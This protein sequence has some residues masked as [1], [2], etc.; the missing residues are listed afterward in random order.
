M[1]QPGLPTAVEPANTT[2]AVTPAE[3]KQAARRLAS[4]ITIVT[5]RLGNTVH[6]ATV[7]AFATLSL[8]PMQVLVSLGRDGRL[9]AM[10]RDSGIFAVSILG[11]EQEPVSRAFAVS[12]PTSEDAFPDVATHVLATGA[13]V[14]DGALA[15]FDCT[16]ANTFDSGDHTIFAGN[17]HAVRTDDGGLPLLYFNGGYGTIRF[18]DQPT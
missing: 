16:I 15:C 11:A 6:G 13:P 9:A 3:F 4:G 8:E 2:A 7:S 12:R 5:T 18:S 10:L 1:T 14:V 17:V